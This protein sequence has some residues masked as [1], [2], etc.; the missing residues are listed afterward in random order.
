MSKDKIYTSLD[1][2]LAEPEQVFLLNL[3]VHE[4]ETLPAEI[5]QL[6]NLPGGLHHILI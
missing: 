6:K 1:E 3:Y 5:G 4:L 2:A